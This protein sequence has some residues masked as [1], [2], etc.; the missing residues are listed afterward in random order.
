MK[1]FSLGASPLFLLRSRETHVHCG[2]GAKNF[3]QKVLVAILVKDQ[4]A[5][6]R[7]VTVVES[8]GQNCDVL[9][10]VL[11]LDYVG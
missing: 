10:A 8:R 7:F 3:S 4:F 1:H 2:I 5:T 11:N 9:I 6:L